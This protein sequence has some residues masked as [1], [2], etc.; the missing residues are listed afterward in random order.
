MR[1]PASSR[2]GPTVFWVAVV[3][4][5]L[6]VAWGV[7]FAE[8]LTAVF[9]AA[10]LNFM[11]PSFGL[12]AVRGHLHSPR[13]PGPDHPRVRRRRDSGTQRCQ[14]RVVRCPATFGD[15]EPREG[16]AQGWALKQEPACRRSRHEG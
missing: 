16:G 9:D 5:A 6:F 10:L 7:F 1:G 13:L 11:V 14:L 4:P 8:R 3:L 12:G 2:I 15:S